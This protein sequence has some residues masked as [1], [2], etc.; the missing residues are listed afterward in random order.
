MQTQTFKV[1]K[2][3]PG[4]DQYETI[5]IDCQEVKVNNNDFYFITSGQIVAIVKNAQSAIAKT[6]RPD[7]IFSNNVSDM[8]IDFEFSRLYPK[9]RRK[10]FLRELFSDYIYKIK[11]ECFKSGAQFAMNK[12]KQSFVTHI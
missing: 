11:K 1:L 5:Y 2:R 8:E 10:G 4:S 3:L 6:T 12:N 7:A 9:D